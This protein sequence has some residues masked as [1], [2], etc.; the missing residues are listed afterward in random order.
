[1]W[2]WVVVFALMG[3]PALALTAVG[4]GGP[5]VQIELVAQIVNPEGDQMLNAYEPPALPW[6]QL[7]VPANASASLRPDALAAFRGVERALGLVESPAAVR[8][9]C[10]R[11]TCTAMVAAQLPGGMVASAPPGP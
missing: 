6:V 8:I 4:G 1:M 5:P 10:G 2:R 11:A 3:C 9:E 7:S